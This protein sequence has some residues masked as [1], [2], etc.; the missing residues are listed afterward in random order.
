[1]F[2]TPGGRARCLS[3]THRPPFYPFLSQEDGCAGP[4]WGE[5]SHENLEAFSTKSQDLRRKQ[6]NGSGPVLALIP[7]SFTPKFFA[8]TPV[9]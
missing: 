1:M 3:H 2:R 7:E 4:P 6:R 8:V 9:A 5:A